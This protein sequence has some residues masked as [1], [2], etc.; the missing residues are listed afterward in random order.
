MSSRAIQTSRGPQPAPPLK[1][2]S[3]I[4]TLTSDACIVTLDV[5]I[6]GVKYQFIGSSRRAPGDRSDKG[7]GQMVALARA[8][9][10]LAR[11]LSKRASG[12]VSHHDSVQEHQRQI[13]ERQA[14]AQAAPRRRV[15]K[16]AV[17]RRAT[18]RKKVAAKKVAAR[19]R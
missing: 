1:I 15:A 17:T 14:A 9:G 4:S 11:K 12:M 16:K 8:Y 5:E 3:E 19:K 13:K 18:P 6:Q 7:V 10:S 2:L